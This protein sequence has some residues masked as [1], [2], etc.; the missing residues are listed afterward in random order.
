MS[1]FLVIDGTACAG[2]TTFIKNYN[3]VK[4][5][6]YYGDYKEICDKYDLTSIPHDLCEVMFCAHRAYND[7]QLRIEYLDCLIKAD[8]QPTSTM[9]YKLIREKADEAEIKRVADKCKRMG[10]MRNY[11][12][13]TV[14]VKPGAEAYVVEKMK[15]RNNGI[16][17]AMK[18]DYVIDQNRVF[19]VWSEHLKFPIVQVDGGDYETLHKLLNGIIKSKIRKNYSIGNDCKV[20]EYRLPII[21]KSVAVV[22]MMMMD[23]ASISNEQFANAKTNLTNM[24]K[25]NI[26]IIYWSSDESIMER[27]VMPLNVPG[28][29][30]FCADDD[31]ILQSVPLTHYG[32]VLMKN[33]LID[34]DIN[35]TNKYNF[36]DL[37]CKIIQ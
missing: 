26:T 29:V 14:L 36:N 37:C 13:I 11:E 21:N 28:V 10:L 32:N 35:V 25:S 7:N 31:A 30:Y 34:D 5:T 3:D 9:V 15:Q 2:K 1:K 33:E 19:R 16:D 12:T 20:C 27:I 17:N 6:K 23:D 8:R 22:M 18:E 24:I 4:M